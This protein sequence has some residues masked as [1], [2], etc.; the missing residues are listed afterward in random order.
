MK[1]KKKKT[2]NQMKTKKKRRKNIINN[3]SP[4]DLPETMVNNVLIMHSTMMMS[5]V[6]NSTCKQSHIVAIKI[7]MVVK[8]LI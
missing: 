7:T 1:M 6:H 2:L 8:Q 4:R 5:R 3:I